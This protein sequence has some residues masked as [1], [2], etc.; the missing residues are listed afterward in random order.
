MFPIYVF[1]LYKK[2]FRIKIFPKFLFPKTIKTEN[3]FINYICSNSSQHV[4]LK[5]IFTSSN[6]RCLFFYLIMFSCI[7][8]SLLLLVCSLETEAFLKNGL[9]LK[10]NFIMGYTTKCIAISICQRYLSL[11]AIYL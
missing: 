1:S 3:T 10:K 9:M 11:Y 6:V 8:D 7:W 5:W 2:L 4:K